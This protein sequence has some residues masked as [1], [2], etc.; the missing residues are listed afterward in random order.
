M[1]S[2]EVEVLVTKVGP[3][4]N[5][6][7]AVNPVNMKMSVTVK[8]IGTVSVVTVLSYF[9]SVLVSSW[10]TCTVVESRHVLVSVSQRVRVK[11]QTHSSHGQVSGQET[12]P[13]QPNRHRP[14]GFGMMPPTHLGQDWSQHFTWRGGW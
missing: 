1:V 11:Q 14:P 12:P 7:E 13:G 3:V 10:M 6:V 9:C 4:A 2:I 8:V 5:R